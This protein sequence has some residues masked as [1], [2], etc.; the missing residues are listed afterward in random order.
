METQPL[1]F[2]L[3]STWSTYEALLHKAKKS[4]SSETIHQLRVSTQRLE[5]ILVLCRGVIKSTKWF[6]KIIDE[7]RKTRRQIGG[8]RDLYVATQTVQSWKDS[9]KRFEEFLK[10]KIKQEKKSD[11]KFL[12][13]LPLKKQRQH[14]QELANRLLTIEETIAPEELDDLVDMTLSQT[15]KQ[16]NNTFEKIQAPDIK[17]LHHFRIESKRLRYQKEFLSPDIVHDEEI[18]Y[19][20]SI[21]DKI[22]GFLDERVLKKRL[23]RFLKLS[24]S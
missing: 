17:S 9:S 20:R 10:S 5:A 11:R 1:S 18:N 12:K 6:D 21:Q 2:S 22:G 7:L 16:L 14:V 15:M 23:E 24:P 3:L 8:L 4:P 19:L 13:S